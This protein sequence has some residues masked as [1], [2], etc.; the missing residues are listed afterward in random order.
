MAIDYSAMH[1]RPSRT[2][3]PTVII[4]ERDQHDWVQVN[5]DQGLVSISI[6][7]EQ[8]RDLA[9]KL[10]SALYDYDITRSDTREEGLLDGYVEAFEAARDMLEGEPF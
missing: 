9:S 7:I 10:G 3:R 6:S 5:F 4:M 1:V 8:A 2:Y